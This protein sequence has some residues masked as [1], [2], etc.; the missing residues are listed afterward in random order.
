MKQI[1]KN[2]SKLAIH[3][4][5]TKPWDIETAVKKYSEQGI[6][7]ITI[8]RQYLEG[9][10]IDL[11]GRMIKDKGMNIISL[12]RGGFFPHPQLS[13]REEA[14]AENE[15]AIHQANALNAPMIV[16]VCGSHPDQAL[17]E[18]RQQIVEGIERILPLAERLN[19]RLGIE[20][21]HPMYADSR[22]A[23]NT[24]KQAN[25]ICQEITSNYLG[26]VIDVYHLWWDPQLPEEIDRCGKL[27]KI[28]AFHISDW[29][30]PTVDLLNDR[31]L[32][33]DG[34]IPI[35]KIK[36]RVEEAGF[37]GTHEVEIFSN[38]YWQ[39]DQDKFLQMIIRSYGDHCL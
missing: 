30:T 10:D 18:S 32:M 12:C 15:N 21:L 27:D 6:K 7:N 38:K 39:I 36:N 9:R 17:D 5:T 28:F 25:D 26:V 16:L 3:T 2:L 31:G 22:S 33:G 37:T 34:C 14:I 35:R 29:I 13:K 11:V 24:I 1:M 20:P 4:I 23:I 8:W 19:V